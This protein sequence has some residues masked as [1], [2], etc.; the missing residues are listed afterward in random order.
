M[1]SLL[2]F[3]FF[4]SLAI[5]PGSVRAAFEIPDLIGPVVDKAG[6]LR[7]QDEQR[8]AKIAD[9][10]RDAGLAQIQVLTVNSLDGEAVEQAS[11]QVIEKW[12]LGT[13][14]KDNGILIFVAFKERKIRIEVGQGLEGI[15][16]DIVAGRIIRDVMVPYFR[17]EDA[18][19]GI[20][21]GVYSIAQRIEPQALQNI[22]IK[23][24]KRDSQAG[25]PIWKIPFFILLIF[26]I[27][28]QRLS[29]G[30]RFLRR[31]GYG[32]YGGFGGGGF[33]GGGFGGGWSGGG[34]GFSGGGSSGSW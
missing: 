15:V 26:F 10:F 19:A 23:K 33:G 16:P 31:R 34:G 11:L 1:K 25:V 3:L 9:A 13:A 30:G 5:A 21:A 22:G 6:I 18:S 27:I 4:C 7:T 29:G 28:V 8:I 12:K 32:G 20:L 2:K 14:E 24:N 17:D